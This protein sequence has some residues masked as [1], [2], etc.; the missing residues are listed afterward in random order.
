MRG[1]ARVQNCTQL[2]PPPHTSWQE[3][4]S[5]LQL[6]YKVKRS[7]ES[8]LLDYTRL[9]LLRSSFSIILHH[10][11]STVLRPRKVRRPLCPVIIG[12]VAR[13][14]FAPVSHASV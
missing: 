3:C 7:L 4:L 10:C 12:A 1:K 14:G 13:G 11:Y 5:G 9:T 2:M 6:Q 8:R